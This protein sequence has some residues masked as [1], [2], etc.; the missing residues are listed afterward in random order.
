MLCLLSIRQ[1]VII[2]Y[3]VML[4]MQFYNVNETGFILSLWISAMG[5]EAAALCDYRPTV[6][7]FLLPFP[8]FGL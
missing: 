7:V 2:S 1:I 3:K 4:N 5:S 6:A 8:S